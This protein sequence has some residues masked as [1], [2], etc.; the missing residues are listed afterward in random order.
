M[1]MVTVFLHLFLVSLFVFLHSHQKH[2]KTSQKRGD[3]RVDILFT[4]CDPHK[5]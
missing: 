2:H 3:L 5:T 4:K 1:V